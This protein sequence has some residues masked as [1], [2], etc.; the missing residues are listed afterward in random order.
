MAASARTAVVVTPSGSVSE[1]KKPPSGRVGLRVGHVRV[2]PG[3]AGVE[4]RRVSAFSRSI[5]GAEQA[6]PAPFVGDALRDVAGRD[7]RVLGDLARAWRSAAGVADHEAGADARRDE[8]GE[9]AHMQRALGRERVERRLLLAAI[10]QQA[11]RRV[12]DEQEPVLLG[13]LDDAPPLRA[14]AGR[15]GRVLEVG[16]DVEELRRAAVA[17]AASSASMFGP[18]ASSGMPTTVGAVAAQQRDACGRRSATR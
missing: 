16:D 3:Q 14:R 17:S 11:V 1:M 8:L 9:R 7:V 4:P 15:A 18:S 12:F 2:E 5:C 13:E 6:A 10:A